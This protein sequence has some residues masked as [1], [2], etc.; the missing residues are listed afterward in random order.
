ME[1]SGMTRMVRVLEYVSCVVFGALVAL[2]GTA[3]HR[4]YD[5]FG[6][7]LAILAVFVAAVMVRAWLGL[8]GVGIFGLTLLAVIQMFALQGPGGDVLMPADYLTY[9]WLAGGILAVGIACFTP[10]IWFSEEEN[11][12]VSEPAA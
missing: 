6:V 5:P 12:H 7:I 9:L 3:M 10:R 8:V 2:L 11:Q 1:T 4:A